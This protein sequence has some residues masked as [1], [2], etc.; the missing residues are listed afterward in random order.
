[1]ADIYEKFL[2]LVEFE[3]DEMPEILPAWR[4]TCEKFGL[5]EDDMKFAMEERLPAHF[6]LE[7]KGVRKMLGGWIRELIDVTKTPEYKENGVK[8]VYGILPLTSYFYYSLKLTAGEAVYAGLPDYIMAV[9]LNMIFHKLGPYLEEA[10]AHGMSYGCRHCPLNKTRYAARRLGLI[11]APDVMW[12]WGFICDEGPKSDEFINVYY[13]PEWKTYVSRLP[14]DQP[15]YSVEDEDVERVKYLADQMKDGF[16]FVQRQTGIKV[17]DAKLMEAIGIYQRYNKKYGELNRL[18]TSD[19]QPLGGLTCMVFS[20][21]ILN[22]FNTGIDHM[23]SALDITIEEVKQRVAQKQGVLPKGAPRLMTWLTPVC[24]PWIAKMFE[25]NGVGM[26][27]SSLLVPTKKQMTKP[28]AFEDPYMV[29]AEL[30]LR[31]EFMVNTGYEVEQILEKLETYT[32][33]GMIFGFID[34]DR[35]LGRDQKLM[36]KIVHE[37]TGLPVFYI[38]GDI[39]DDRDYSPGALRTRIESICEIIKMRKASKS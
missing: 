13:D 16:E 1:M 28:P 25:N 7:M 32:C 21:P 8:L 9:A 29:A 39:W 10:E 20:Q 4:K 38:E 3:E 23:E 18:M 5:T 14:Q 36:A 6:E 34:F 17:T 26:T 27:V 22:P 19:P 31:G 33:D 35:F 24:V 12:V 11:A 15:L 30:W 2:R 37:K